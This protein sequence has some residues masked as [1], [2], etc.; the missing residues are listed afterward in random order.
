MKITMSRKE[1]ADTLKN[2][3]KAVAVKT[4]TPI[5]AGVYLKAENSTLELQA[6]DYSLGIISKVAANVEESG[7]TV[8]VGKKL[9]EIIQKL[10]GDTLTITAD[11]TNSEIKSAGTKYSLLTFNANDFPKVNQEEILQ[12]FTLRQ[13][14]FKKLI[15][16]SAFAAADDKTTLRPIFTGVL[17]HLKGENL[18]LAATNTHRLVVVY[19]KLPEP[20]EGEIKNIVPAKTLENIYSML[21][22]GE[23][24]I[25]F[26]KKT[27]SFAFDSY[28]VT[29]RLISGDFP[30]YER[31]LNEESNIFATLKPQEFLQALE[32]V[33]VIAKE[34]EYNI[35]RFHFDSDG[36]NIFATSQDVGKAEE[37]ISAEVKGGD[38]DISFNYNYLTDALKVIDA[39]NLTIG[40]SGELKPIDFQ[41][42]N[43]RY[44]VTPVRRN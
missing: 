4:M 7:E 20:V 21:D 31:L 14:D 9:F 12:T 6:T 32:R 36:L 40:M 10:T 27:A 37:K 18:T 39:E 25:S 11:D 28:L 2:V 38:L 5:L 8:I 16:Q 44:I 42:D 17:F 41:L 24:K 15:K 26:T 1:F 23:V 43:F 29:A 13:K 22:T 3:L 34:T 35:A 33:A 19:E 30:P